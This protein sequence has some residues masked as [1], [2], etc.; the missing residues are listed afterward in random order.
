MTISRPSLPPER[1]RSSVARKRRSR[2][3]YPTDG[4][5]VDPKIALIGTG[6]G[7]STL[8]LRLLTRTVPTRLL[9]P[10]RPYRSAAC[11]LAIAN[12]VTEWMYSEKLRAI[13]K[14]NDAS[15]DD[16]H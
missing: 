5:W 15:I 13:L 12:T 16:A 3:Q 6:V 8:H 10:R 11:L 9:V 14:R 4:T 2:R 1:S 7:C